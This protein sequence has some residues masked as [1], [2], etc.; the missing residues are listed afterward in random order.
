MSK[1]VKTL[2]GTVM[3][4]AFGAALGRLAG[5][6]VQSDNLPFF[7]ALGALTGLCVGLIWARRLR[8]FVLALISLMTFLLIVILLTPPRAQFPSSAP[9][10]DGGCIAHPT[11]RRPDP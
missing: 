11:A 10:I 7:V 8:L 2:I 3:G 6:L 9:G 4:L 5:T 1:R